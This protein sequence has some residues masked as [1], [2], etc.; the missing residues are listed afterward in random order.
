MIVAARKTHSEKEA[1]LR[2]V[3]TWIEDIALALPIH[4]SIIRKINEV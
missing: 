2:H 1:I 3:E 4:Y